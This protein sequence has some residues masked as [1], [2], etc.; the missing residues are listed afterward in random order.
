VKSGLRPQREGEVIEKVSSRLARSF[1][2]RR[3]GLAQCRLAD[4]YDAAQERG[5]VQQAGGRRG[6]QFANV[7]KENNAK[8]TVADI[9]LTRKQVHEARVVRDAVR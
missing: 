2:M 1:Q 7:P 4:E 5:E 3:K 8:P 6:N 9:G